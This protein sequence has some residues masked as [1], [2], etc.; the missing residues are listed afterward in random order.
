[1][2]FSN[3]IEIKRSPAE[4]FDY[5]ATP[6]NIPD[7]NYAISASQASPSGPIGVGT[8]IRQRRTLPRP[9]EEQLQVTELLPGRRLVLAGDVGPLHGTLSYVLQPTSDGTRLTN[10][11]ELEASGSLRLAAPLFAGRI[12]A[13]V[14]ENLA[15]LKRI[16]ESER[17]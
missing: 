13:A 7:W 9:A 4:V 1:M 16:L 11:A 12:R 14:A 3:T 17:R 2:R 6:E 5:L 15:T 10:A 8:R